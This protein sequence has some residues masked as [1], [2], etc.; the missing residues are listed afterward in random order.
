MQ[1]YHLCKHLNMQ[2]TCSGLSDSLFILCFVVMYFYG[3]CYFL[4]FNV[5][6]FLSCLHA[7]SKL[8][9]LYIH[10]QP[11]ANF[12]FL[13]HAK[14]QI[15][16]PLGSLMA[17]L[18]LRIAQVPTRPPEPFTCHF[19]HP[20]VDWNH[21]LHADWTSAAYTHLL[22]GHA[23]W[24]LC[25]LCYSHTHTKKRHLIVTNESLSHSQS[26]DRTNFSQL[27]IN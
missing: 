24:L 20:V 11:F 17:D 10:T 18:S 23:V 4:S 7:Y 13:C 27:C 5:R 12:L 19:Y 22:T 8:C 1:Y 9:L 6:L 25:Y 21:L 16:F 2:Y 14:F 15:T 3:N 26:K